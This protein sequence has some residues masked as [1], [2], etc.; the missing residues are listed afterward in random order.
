[1]ENE[2]KIKVACIG[3]SITAGYGLADPMNDSY[4][5]VLNKL[6][7]KDRYDV[8]N[9][10]VNGATVLTETINPYI[11]TDEWF[12]ALE[13][14]ADIYIIELGANDLIPGNVNCHENQFVPSYENLIEVVRTNS[15][16]AQIIMT[17]LTP[18]VVDFGMGSDY[19][20]IWHKRV[21]DMVAKV[22]VHCNAKLIDIY[23]P[24]KKVVDDGTVL[25]PDGIHPNAVGAGII[26]Q[27][28]FDS[29]V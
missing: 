1:M 14:C 2:R 11:L 12:N 24:L 27:T 25:F 29:L 19:L 23:T 22:A 13:F 16:R 21:Q 7:G 4:S 6:L 17:S 3:D 26:S 20:D 15:P 5:A 28:I 18:M 10:G 9:F 8:R